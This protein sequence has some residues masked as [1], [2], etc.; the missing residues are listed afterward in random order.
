MKSKQL[1][2]GS[3]ITSLVDKGC[4][5]SNISQSTEHCEIV[6]FTLVPFAKKLFILKEGE[7]YTL[8]TTSPTNK[9]TNK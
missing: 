3:E 1:F 6:L 8:K 5:I 9:Q 7:L 2:P 4:R